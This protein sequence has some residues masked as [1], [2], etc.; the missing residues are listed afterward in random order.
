MR[1]GVGNA[2]AGRGNF[3]RVAARASF[4]APAVLANDRISAPSPLQTRRKRPAKMVPLR[5]VRD[6]YAW[7]RMG[8][9]RLMLFGR[10]DAGMPRL[11]LL[12]MC[13]LAI[14]ARAE[15]PC[16][17]DVRHFCPDVK[18]GAGR[19]NKCLEEHEAQVSQACRV[20][21]EADTERVRALIAE[22][23][24][25][26]QDDSQRLCATVRPGEGRMLT[27]LT[28]NDYALSPKCLAEVT[29]LDSAR[30]KVLALQ[31]QCQPDAERLCP[32][33]MA[34]AG[35]LLA[36]LEDNQADL[37]PACKAA[38]PSIAS[39]AATFVDTVDEMTSKERIQDTVAIL[40]GLNTV[41]FSRNQ[42]GLT[43][44]YLQGVAGKPVN[45][46][47]ITF[48]PLLVFGRGNEFAIQ[49][50]VPVGALF[51]D[52]PPGTAGPSAV[53][54]VGD[55][56]T[57]FGWAF[58]AHGS[59]RQYLALALQWNSSS[60]AALGA[61]WVITP[62]YA[63]AVGLAG[64][65]SLTTEVSW[66]HSLGNVGTYPGVN[67]LVVRPILVF[68]LPSTTF[69]SVDTKL[70]W[71]FLHQVFVPVMR[72]QGGKLI[73]RDRDLSISAWYQLAL[74]KV[75]QQDSFNFGVGFNFSYFFDW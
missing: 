74:N 2:A 50:K 47:E 13:L 12:G 25:A 27:C 75:G 30:G 21:L 29:K 9:S 65:V 40:Q 52:V 22:F 42:L 28:R 48:N 66:N 23:S 61:P 5:P 14:T 17:E 59:V 35:E 58:Y 46:D 70:G 4:E 33:A 56:N 73:G 15:D 60:V 11:A 57:A 41:A 54:G 7:G 62:V 63:L 8:K 72:F 34:H 45:L 6:G 26:C 43:F 16:G 3:L 67:L 64:W 51:P 24:D 10:V 32:K 37:S 71:D 1:R 44:D 19:V 49:V 38:N 69:L 55:I 20:K 68:N 18:P 31:R 53:S 36:C 39:E